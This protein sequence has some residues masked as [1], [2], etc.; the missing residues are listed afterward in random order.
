VQILEKLVGLDAAA[1]AQLTQNAERLASTGTEKQRAESEQVLLAIRIERR[2]RTVLETTR[3]EAAKAAIIGRVTDLDLFD[4][5]LLAFQEM[6]P[7]DWEA[8]ALQVVANNPGRDY[9][10]LAQALG[11]KDGGYMNLA[12][13][14]LCSVREVYL[15]QA[16]AAEKRKNE[17]FYSG[18]LVDMTPHQE[19][20]GST[21]HGWNLKTE[22]LAA[23]AQL[24]IVT[25]AV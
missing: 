7:E 24:G 6:P 10:F 8:E 3:K 21:W 5:V 12:M 16:P 23:L 18:L 19:K 20:D 25:K 11:K 4:R 17:K 15:G 1:L 14:S 2:R 13:G 9:H 22:A